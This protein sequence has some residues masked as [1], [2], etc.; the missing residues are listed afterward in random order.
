MPK[1]TSSA[2]VTN[3]YLSDSGNNT[4]SNI[5]ATKSNIIGTESN[6]IT[7]SNMK[8]EK[9][10]KKQSGKKSVAKGMTAPYGRGFTSGQAATQK[11][12]L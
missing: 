8:Q 10:Q 6:V 7:M 12:P 5:I 11:S 1:I 2:T 9:T 3:G 4:E